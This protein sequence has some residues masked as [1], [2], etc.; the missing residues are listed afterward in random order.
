MRQ[1]A[2]YAAYGKIV[3]PERAHSQHGQQQSQGTAPQR[4]TAYS[5]GRKSAESEVAADEKEQ[6]HVHLAY[7]F[8]Q[9]G[10]VDAADAHGEHV[11][12]HHHEYGYS[13]QK[14]R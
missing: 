11:S 7:D 2:F 4:R 8:E 14:I 13:F 6:R 1:R 10:A 9:G 12:H 3:D 5:A